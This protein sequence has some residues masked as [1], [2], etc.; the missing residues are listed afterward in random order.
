VS[1]P[2]DLIAAIEAAY[3]RSVD[4]AAWLEQLARVVGPSFSAGPAATSAFFYEVRPKTG[5]HL[6]NV[7]SVGEKPHTR[8][9]FEK[10]HAA[11]SPEAHYMAYECDM[12]T[13]LSRVVGKESAQQSFHAA[14]ID[15]GDSLGLRAN[16]TP[17]SGI[18]LTTM[19]P[20]GHRIRQRTIWTRFAAHLGSAARLRRN[21]ERPAPEAALAVLTPNGKLEHGTAETI[22]ARTD[23]ATAAQ[24]MDRARGKMRR[25]DP[26]AA[27]ALWRTMVRGEWSLVDWFDHDGKRFLLAQDNRIGSTPR[28]QLSER[29]HQVLAC[30]AMGHTNKLIAYDLGLSP[31]TVGVILSRA[32]KK[33]GAS[34]RLALIRSYR[35]SLR[36]GGRAPDDLE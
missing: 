32:A 19:V 12:F 31:G 22:A 10:Q 13:L 4:D 8:D 11:A 28:L 26:E 21:R 33:L 6:S 5:A 35:E 18:M 30:A 23:L 29:E 24:S 36:G 14:G 25:I 34:S 20:E 27:S 17:D 15:G 1:K 2:L 7:V 16:V 3:D 9:Q